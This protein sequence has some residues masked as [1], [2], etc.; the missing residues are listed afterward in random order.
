MSLGDISVTQIRK[1]HPN[2]I[3]F[4]NVGHQPLLVP[5]DDKVLADEAAVAG[6]VDRHD[7]VHVLADGADEVGKGDADAVGVGGVVWQRYC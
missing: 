5:L 2:I 4:V 3:E 6:V 7:D 1:D